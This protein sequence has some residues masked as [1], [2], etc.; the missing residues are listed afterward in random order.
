M[1]E[2]AR[3]ADSLKSQI[4]GVIAADVAQQLNGPR[5]S[6]YTTAGDTA[7]AWRV[8]IDV[9]RFDATLGDAVTVDALWS[10]SPPGKPA[11]AATDEFPRACNARIRQPV[12]SCRRATAAAARSVR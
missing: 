2:F 5:V 4:P 7:A 3:W 8:Q 6:A 12:R 9:Q 10:V 11:S 1:N